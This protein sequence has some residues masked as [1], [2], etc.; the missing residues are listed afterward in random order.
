[1]KKVLYTLGM[2]L[3]VV[4]GIPILLLLCV[5]YLLYVPFDFIR[6]RRTPYYKDLGAKYEFFVSSRDIVK[7]YNRTVR[8]KLPIQYFN[9]EGFEYFVKDGQVLLCGWGGVSFDEGMGEWIFI[10]GEEK[11]TTMPMKE[12]LEN[13]VALIKPEHRSL[14]AKFLVFYNDITDRAKFDYATLCPYFYCVFSADDI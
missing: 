14:P 4:V 13:E 7:L 10:L 9:H 8:E 1:M 5:G 3:C 12:V 11:Y 6:Y 2:C